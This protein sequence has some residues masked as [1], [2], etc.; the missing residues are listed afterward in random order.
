MISYLKKKEVLLILRITFQLYHTEFQILLKN[1]IS[2][3]F[4]F[5]SVQTYLLLISW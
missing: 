4:I 3:R 2:S 1:Y 5:R